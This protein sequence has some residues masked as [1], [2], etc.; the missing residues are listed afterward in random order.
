MEANGS[1]EPLPRRS[2]GVDHESLQQPQS[3][4]K[5]KGG[6]ITFP[7]LGGLSLCLRHLSSAARRM[8]HVCMVWCSGH[9]GAWCGD[10]RR[11]EQPGRYLIKEY[12][13][14]SVDAAQISNII[15]GCI[16]LAPVA[17]AIVADA[18]F[19][20]YTLSS[21]SPWPSPSW[22]PLVVFTLTASLHGLRP[23]PCQPAAA[24]PCEPASAG[25]MAVLYAGVFLMC[26]SAAGSRINQ[27]TMGADQFD[28]AADRNVLFNWFFIFFY[29]S[30][31]LGSTVIVYVQDTVS[32][33]L[34]FGVSAAASVVG[35][36]ALLLG[37]RYY[38]QS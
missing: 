17:G 19:G 33:T 3:D 34:G 24:G 31:V 37:S 15:A 4:P 38:R 6:W 2:H 22:S 20:C 5:R 21:R 10:E 7:F 30:S 1:Q 28:S 32:W 8:L 11:L 14:P 26:V 12:N 36:A 35:L 29:T 23:V 13:M 25:Q 9:D 27:A 16:S 18:F